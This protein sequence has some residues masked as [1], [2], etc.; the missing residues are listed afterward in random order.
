MRIKIFMNKTYKTTQYIASTLVAL[1]IAGPLGVFAQTSTSTPS[2]NGKDFCD[3]LGGISTNLEKRIANREDQFRKMKD[4]RL[5]KFLKSASSTAERLDGSRDHAD[6]NRKEHYAKLLERA[7]TDAQKQAVEKFR[8]AMDAAIATR[9]AAIDAAIKTFQAD[10]KSMLGSR[11]GG[12]EKAAADF[13]TGEQA[14]IKEA[15]D[16][17][18]SGTNIKT[19]RQTLNRKLQGLQRDFEGD[20][21]D[22]NRLGVGLDGLTKKRAEAFRVAR[23]A[24]EVAA[25]KAR[26][27]LKAALGE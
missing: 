23:E 1:T 24:Y 8:A 7:D 6:E 11:K 21:R 25:R 9:R 26:L 3:R 20:R 14:A 12:L 5:E 18:K 27:E 4:N 13:R 10:V 22:A 17:C 2:N 16:A 15:Q 19:V